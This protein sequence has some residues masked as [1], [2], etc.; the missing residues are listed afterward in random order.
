MGA[1]QLV[2]SPLVGY[3]RIF[4]TCLAVMN[5]DVAGFVYTRLHL[6]SAN[7]QKG[8]FQAIG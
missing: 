7:N 2:H 3:L 8:A 6:C 5:K 1:P 4:P